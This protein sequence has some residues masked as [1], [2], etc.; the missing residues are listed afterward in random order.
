M[1]TIKNRNGRFTARIR[2]GGIQTAKTFGKKGD[3]A[4]WAR[5]TETAIENGTYETDAAR[6]TREAREAAD[7]VTLATAI[8]Q[9]LE[10]VDAGRIK[11]RKG[12]KILRSDNR[13]KIAFWRS[14][15]GAVELVNLKAGDIRSTIDRE[16]R[17]KVA[18]AGRRAGKPIAGATIN[19]YVTELSAVLTYAVRREWIVANVARN[20]DAEPETGR[21]SA[22]QINLE[23]NQVESMLDACA[24][25]S[26]N[27]H[28]FALMAYET[29][30]RS[31]E[32]QKLEWSDVDLDAAVATFRETKNGKDRPVPLSAGVVSIL[33][34]RKRERAERLLAGGGM[35][36]KA[37]A[38]GRVFEAKTVRRSRDE[39]GEL[40]IE[41]AG[42]W[43]YRHDWHEARDAAGL[44]GYEFKWLRNLFVTRASAAGVPPLQIAEIVGHS[45][46]DMVQHYARHSVDH[47]GDAMSKVNG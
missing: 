43:E 35:P 18:H 34:A 20:L 41:G 26:E 9:Y 8:D 6:S 5:E 45:S 31:G 27:L 4:R 16:L 38:L 30:C 24:N 7:R 39:N 47:L 19:R 13:L 32:L 46:L 11:G 17:S 1:A 36:S 2:K 10:D 28:L 3:A 23:A 29:G 40:T 33:A 14:H 15:L 12:A 22:D 25:V 42:I 44:V 37:S 21:P